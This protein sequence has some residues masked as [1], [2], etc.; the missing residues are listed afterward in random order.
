MTRVNPRYMPNL[1]RGAQQN[2]AFTQIERDRR[3]EVL[4]S[5]GVDWENTASIAARAGLRLQPVCVY[6]SDLLHLGFVETRFEP[7]VLKNG[8][9]SGATQQRKMQWRSATQ[10]L[11]EKR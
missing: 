8:E 6:L 11:S 1:C 7:R 5:V 9:C 10:R 4:K 3:H 2:F